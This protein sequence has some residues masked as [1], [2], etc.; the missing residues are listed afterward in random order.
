LRKDTNAELPDGF[1]S[2][3]MILRSLPRSTGFNEVNDFYALASA[4]RGRLTLRCP[5]TYAAAQNYAG[6]R[7]EARLSRPMRD[8]AHH[9]QD[10]S[11]CRVPFLKC[12]LVFRIDRPRA[13]F[14]LNLNNQLHATVQ[15]DL[16]AAG[17]E[18]RIVTEFKIANPHDSLRLSVQHRAG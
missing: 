5:A 7:V 4:A 11:A 9:G 6:L 16:F 10:V 18:H 3:L 17:P 2:S 15:L 1:L 12:I 8:Y 14:E 13:S